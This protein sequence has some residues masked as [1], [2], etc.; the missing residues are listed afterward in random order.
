MGRYLLLAALGSAILAIAVPVSAHTP[1]IPTRQYAIAPGSLRD[2]LDALA[3]QGNA[4]IIYAPE[5]VAGKRAPGI[6]GRYTLINALR[7]LLTGT[8]L[9]W[10]TVNDSTIVLQPALLPDKVMHAVMTR[11]PIS[12]PKTLETINISGSLIGN[13][14][15]QTATPTYTISFEE[16]RTSGFNSVAEILQNS[17]LASG[18]VQGPQLAGSFTQGA[19]AISLFGLGPEFTSI[20]IDGKPVANFGRLYDGTINFSNLANIPMSMIDHIDVMPGGSS[21]IYGSQAVAGVINIVTRQHMDGGEIS[22]GT[23]D[24]AD[25]GGASQRM[26]FAYGHDFQKLSVL[27]MLEFDNAAPIWGYQRPLTAGPPSGGTSMP[28]IQSGILNY[29]TIDSFTGYPLGFLDPPAGCSSNLFGGSTAL[30]N[31]SASSNLAG[32][33]CGSPKMAGYTTYSNQSRSYDGMLKLRYDVNDKL[34][35]YSD[36]LLDWQQQKWFPAVLEWFPDD[37]PGGAIEDAGSGNILYPEK[38]FAPEEMLNGTA[39]QMDRQQDLLYQIDIGANGQFGESDWDW[40]AYYLRSGD[41]T[42]VV[43]SLAIADE[44]DRFFVNMFQPT[45]SSDPATGLALY[46]PNY[47]AFFQPVTPAQYA[48]FTEGVG[49]SSNTWINSTR[50]TISNTRLF[51]LAGGDAGLAV[52]AEGGNEAWY[53][54]LNPLFADADIY[55]H[56]TTGGGGRRSHL[57]S[58]FELNLPLLKQLTVDLSGRYD[59]YALDDGSDNSKF[60]YKAGIEYRPFDSLLLRGNYATAFKAPDLSTIYLGPSD[61]YTQVTDYYLCAQAQS[62]NCSEYQTSVLGESRAS[63]SLQPTTARSWAVGAIWSPD[64]RFSASID[65]IHASIDDEIVAQSTDLLMQQDAQ[66]LLGQ[67]NPASAECQAITNAVNGQVQRADQG[68][69][70]GPVI[71]ITTYYANLAN[72]VTD[73]LIASGRYQ[74]DPTRLGKFGLQLDYSDMLKHSYQ[75]APGQPPFDELANPLYSAGFKSV[76]SGALSWTSPNGQWK[77]TWYGHRYGS[78]P[79]YTA[80][81]YGAAY[82]G[83]GWLHP[84][85]TFNWSLRYTPIANLDLAVL[86]NNIANRMPPVDATYTTYPYFNVE[87]YNIY[88]REILLQ[89]TLKFGGKIH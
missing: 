16:I 13:I 1:P 36:V 39:G 7:L 24:F 61:Y 46:Q 30:I 44:I 34:R 22:V 81:T 21:T 60:T 41:R 77:S 53:Q 54:P 78:S 26:S 33:Y 55:E 4:Q 3:T 6:S 23:G 32:H 67:I 25:G 20:L 52:L 80:A 87:N 56:A 8:P 88:G 28:S 37:L 19:R 2:A 84:W 9:T 31:I 69:V 83:S 27:A 49:E 57:A 43:E 75:L 15:I 58:A 86:V 73:S 47:T 66:C 65:Y 35:L 5:L 59:H 82:A 64:S 51:H 74:S 72:E 50:L 12:A 10:K 40:D 48:S 79:N 38:S 14:Q 68:G 11:E 45:G 62:S 71:G 29:G 76:L 63:R 18:S 17:V 85:I 42:E 70:P 89:A